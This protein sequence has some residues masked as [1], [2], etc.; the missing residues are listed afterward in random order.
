MHAALRV[1]FGH[2][3]VQNAAA[4]SHPLHVTGGHFAF[5]AETV[6]VFYGASQHVCNGLDPTVWMPRESGPVVIRIVI[7]EIV[8]QQERVEL[9]RFAETERAFELYARALNSRF[10]LDDV[11]NGT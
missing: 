5:I 11:S 6:A 4:R 3:L 1:A 9:F 2:F 7:P 10:R 8:Q